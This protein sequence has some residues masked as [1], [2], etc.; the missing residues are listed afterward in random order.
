[1]PESSVPDLTSALEE[2][3]L[4]KYSTHVSGGIISVKALF[5]TLTALNLTSLALSLAQQ[6]SQ[7]SWGY[8]FFND[9][10]P[11]N[12]SIWELYVSPAKK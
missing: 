11:A 6:T 5:P 7:P 3:I 1:M 12:S 2:D 4:T 9:L 8:M 10:E